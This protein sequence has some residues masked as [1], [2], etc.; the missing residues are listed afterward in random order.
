MRTIAATRN[1]LLPWV[2][3]SRRGPYEL[4]RA[5]PAATTSTR[6]WR[7]AIRPV[8]CASATSAKLLQSSLCPAAVPP[9]I[10]F[11]VCT[12]PET[13][14]F[15]AVPAYQVSEKREEHEGKSGVCKDRN[16]PKAA[17]RPSAGCAGVCRGVQFGAVQTR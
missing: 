9:P 16:P 8:R 12:A 10:P 3:T 11:L 17:R 7:L 15:G 5:A 1:P 14:L 2:S 4:Q 6:A 13:P